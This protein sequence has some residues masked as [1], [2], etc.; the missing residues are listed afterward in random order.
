[1]A[2]G[3]IDSA[4]KPDMGKGAAAS[5]DTRS[6]AEKAADIT[7]VEAYLATIGSIVADFSQTS[8]MRL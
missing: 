4:T 3:V 7:R 1:M 6:M 2:R 5:K 8:A